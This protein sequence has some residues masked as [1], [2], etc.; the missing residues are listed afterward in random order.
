[1]YVFET[2]SIE[3][4]GNLYFHGK[5]IK[6]SVFPYAQIMCIFMCT[7]FFFSFLSQFFIFANLIGKKYFLQFGFHGYANFL[8]KTH[9]YLFIT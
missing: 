4:V 2:L 9:F 8:E 1:M 6:F 3:A 5:G 7:G